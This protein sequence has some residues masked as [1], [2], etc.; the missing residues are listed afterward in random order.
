VD[1]SGHG[2]EGERADG[3]VKR[4]FAPMSVSGVR[5]VAYDHF[6]DLHHL[7]DQLDERH[8]AEWLDT[9]EAEDHRSSARRRPARELSTASAAP[10]LKSSWYRSFRCVRRQP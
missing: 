4:R 10:R 7:I 6:A 2:R 3:G 1:P 9:L 5:S 8:Q